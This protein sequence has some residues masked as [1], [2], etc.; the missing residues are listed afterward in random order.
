M[1][2][3]DYDRLVEGIDQGSDGENEYQIPGGKSPLK[4]SK[5]LEK[6]I[7]ETM[8][9]YDE[10]DETAALNRYVME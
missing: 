6:K 1:H 10:V 2:D 7:K 8:E 4:I 9:K 3:S 5:E